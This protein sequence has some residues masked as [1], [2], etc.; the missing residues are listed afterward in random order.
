MTDWNK[1]MFAYDAL[2]LPF[3]TT[4][5]N[6]YDIQAAKDTAGKIETGRYFKKPVSVRA[7]RHLLL[8]NLFILW[9]LLLLWGCWN[10]IWCSNYRTWILLITGQDVS[11]C[12]CIVSGVITLFIYAIVLTSFVILWRYKHAAQQQ[13]ALSH[14]SY[15]LIALMPAAQWC[16]SV[17]TQRT[18]WLSWPCCFVFELLLLH[19]TNLMKCV[20]YCLYTFQKVVALL[21][22]KPTEGMA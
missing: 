12:F 7:L 3:K 8:F 13:M 20:K 17:I 6:Q 18:A 4:L 19:C 15:F 11:S 22:E 14:V 10:E 9:H 2:D 16:K 5:I 21:Q 1:R